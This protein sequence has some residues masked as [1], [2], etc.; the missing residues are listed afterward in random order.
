MKQNK[1]PQHRTYQTPT[2]SSFWTKVSHLTESRYS[3]MVMILIFS[4]VYFISFQNIFDQKP[5]LNGDNFAYYDLAQSLSQG[6]GYTNSF[7]FYHKPH[8]HFPPGYPAFISL[9]VQ[10]TD[11]PVLLLK[12]INGVLFYLALIILFFILLRLSIPV[13]LA[14]LSI[15]VLPLNGELMRW[16]TIM[17]G[18][19]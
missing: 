14:G 19:E 2:S 3:K 8:T 10:H 4:A 5:D 17:M 11:H 13:F 7:D 12:R 18:E 1:S 9:F 6:K 15:I 16:A